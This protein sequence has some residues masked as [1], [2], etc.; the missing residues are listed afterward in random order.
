M[1][2]PCDGKD[3]PKEGETLSAS[4][5]Y[6]HGQTMLI[7]AKVVSRPV[8]G[9]KGEHKFTYH[10]LEDITSN[11]PNSVSLSCGASR[12]YDTYDEAVVAMNEAIRRSLCE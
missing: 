8:E 12:W 3:S 10:T 2:Y 4:L 1:T 6:D 9:V 11:N 5:R 7:Y